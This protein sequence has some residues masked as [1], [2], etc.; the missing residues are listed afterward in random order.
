MLA[1]SFV[2]VG[3]AVAAMTSETGRCHTFDAAADG[4]CRGEGCGVVMLGI[5]RPDMTS[6]KGGVAATGFAVKHNGQSATFTALNSI[7]QTRLMEACKGARLTLAVEAHGTGTKLGDP[8]EIAGLANFKKA[9]TAPRTILNA[10]KAN[11]GHTEPTAGAAGYL[12]SLIVAVAN[13]PQPNAALRTANPVA[14]IEKLDCLAPPTDTVVA[15]ATSSPRAFSVG[16][17]SF[18]Y[19]GIIAHAVLK[20]V[21]CIDDDDNDLSPTL[22][23]KCSRREL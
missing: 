15:G 20:A 9:T 8:I 22:D 10:V 21:A 2:H 17:S 13:E 19:S 1:P 18:G 14:R 4:Y 7:S 3:A 6:L 16:V 23:A 12:A 5:R 11:L